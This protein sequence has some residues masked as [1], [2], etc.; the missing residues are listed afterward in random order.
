MRFNIFKNTVLLFVLVMISCASKGKSSTNEKGEIL[1][2]TSANISTSVQNDSTIVVGANQTDVYL[3]LL[4]G[5]RI[6]IVANQSSV[7]FI[8]EKLKTKNRS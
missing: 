4:I 3:P 2:H 1:D 6:G 8:D 7:I 5:K